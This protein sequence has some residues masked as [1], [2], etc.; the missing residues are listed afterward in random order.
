M[1]ELTIEE[2]EM[3][4]GGVGPVG[5]VLS[6]SAAGISTY[7]NGGNVGEVIAATT[8]G[9]AA[10]YFGGIASAYTGFTRYAFGGYSVGMGVM[11]AGPSS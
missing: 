7:A 10:G 4:T 6:G 5:A 8:F 1:R 11:A 9:A 2:T 3:V